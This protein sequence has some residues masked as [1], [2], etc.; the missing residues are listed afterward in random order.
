MEEL[1]ENL[2]NGDKSFA[3]KLGEVLAFARAGVEIFERGAEALEEEWSRE[4]VEDIVR[5]N[6]EHVSRIE[7]A[8]ESSELEEVILNKA[9]ATGS[10]LDD[11]TE[12]YIGD[13]WDE[14]HE[15][16]EWLGF[17]EG[18]AIV[19]WELIVG[20]LKREGS[21]ADFAN[22]VLK[23]HTSVFGKVSDSLRNQ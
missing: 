7:E 2:K 19:H 12:R 6:K 9:Q 11:M 1:K 4:E 22:E 20:F 10:K 15:V 16:L 3:K 17:F 14:A 8:A 23:F 13:E 21:G 18:G 5:T